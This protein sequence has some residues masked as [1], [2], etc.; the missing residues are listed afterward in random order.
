MSAFW[1][2]ALFFAFSSLAFGCMEGWSIATCEV[3]LFLGA[4][5]V[6]WNN[7]EFWS[8][9]KRLWLPALLVVAL[10]I[11]GLVQLVP[12]PAS[13]WETVGS[14]RY[15]RYTEGAEAERLLHTDAYR[16]DPFGPEAEKP[17]PPETWTPQ[18]P[19][20]PK[21]IPASFTPVATGR[22][23]LALA[24]GLC[25]ILLLESVAEES[26]RRLRTLGVLLG[27]LGLFIAGVALIQH[28][29]AARTTLLWIR[30]SRWAP[31]AFG[32]F[33]NPN[34]GAAF[35]NLTLPILYFLLWRYSHTRHTK[36]D[37]LGIRVVCFALLGVHLAA[38]IVGGSRG[39]ALSLLLYPVA[40]I[41]HIG[42][43]RNSK[44]T[45]VVALLLLC[46]LV[47]AA[48]F[49]VHIGLVSDDG[50]MASNAAMPLHKPLLGH[51]IASFGERWP[52]LVSGLP[53][54]S[55]L[56]NDHLEN[57]Y[58]EVYFEA[59]AAPILLSALFACSVLYL[60]FRLAQE[61][62][63]SFWLAPALVAETARAGVDFPARVFPLVGGF[64]L[65]CLLGMVALESQLSP[66][67]LRQRALQNREEDE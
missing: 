24:A 66:R 64:L 56:R 4:A 59:G 30:E 54:L 47:G 40:W 23:L 51:G 49:V 37:Q 8:V 52:A 60:A 34:H 28:Q 1:P 53:L 65:V 15:T 61:G 67:G 41:I 19:P 33:V 29:E 57:E 2:L 38:L 48:I 39:S 35:I 20:L 50:R 25:L 9:P 58:L 62:A 7:R 16:R 26:R 3:I 46:T 18:T 32:P 44:W 27:L 45:L 14:D 17:L 63:A 55:V 10:I 42:G 31:Q 5:V 12:L 36:T 13:W 11:I 21:W 22:A 6:G 43:R